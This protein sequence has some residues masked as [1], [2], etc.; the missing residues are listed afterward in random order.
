MWRDISASRFQK[1]LFTSS[2][3]FGRPIVEKLWHL[4]GLVNTAATY[5]E[6]KNIVSGTGILIAGSK[7]YMMLSSSIGFWGAVPCAVLESWKQPLT[8]P[9]IKPF[10]HFQ[11]LHIPPYPTISNGSTTPDH[12]PPS[13]NVI[14]LIVDNTSHQIIVLCE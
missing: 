4:I 5:V 2:L 7:R 12:I 11:P 13:N 14:V 1:Y 9:A 6:M 8:R 3:L 10:H